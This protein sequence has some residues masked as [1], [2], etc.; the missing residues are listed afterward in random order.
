MPY[1]AF[2]KELRNSG[3]QNDALNKI[4]IILTFLS[5]GE[6]VSAGWFQELKHRGKDDPYPDYEIRAKQV[7][8]YLF[9]D[10]EKGRIIVLGEVKTEK[11]AT[12]NNRQDAGDKTRLFCFQNKPHSSKH[13][14]T[15]NHENVSRTPPH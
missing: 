1:D 7:R 3:N 14:H 9:E 10:T 6:R 11:N 8:V 13:N 4:R 2:C 12:T 5:Q 15:T